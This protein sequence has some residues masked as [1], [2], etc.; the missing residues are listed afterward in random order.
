MESDLIQILKTMLFSILFSCLAAAL[1]SCASDSS[2]LQNTSWKL[3]QLNG[4]PVLANTA[5][6]LAFDSENASGNS[7][8]NSF[9]GPYS[10]QSD[11]LRFGSLM[12]TLMACMEDGLMQQEGAY[13]SALQATV[14]YKIESEQLFLLDDDGQVLAVFDSVK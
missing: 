6:T 3:V 11:R 7:S 13:L 1:S 5:P 12:S 14:L 4:Q 8:C 10:L 2:A 9:S